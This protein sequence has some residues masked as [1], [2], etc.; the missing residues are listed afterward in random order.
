MDLLEDLNLIIFFK[1][2]E[3]INKRATGIMW[4]CKICCI[5]KERLKNKY[6]KDK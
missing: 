5:C 1:K 2:N 4:K 6:L 3:V